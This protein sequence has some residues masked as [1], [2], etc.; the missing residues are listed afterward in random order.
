MRHFRSELMPSRAAWK[1]VQP[2]LDYKEAG[3]RVHEYE[4]GTWG[5]VAAGK[6]IAK[7]VAYGVNQ[8]AK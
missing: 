8:A 1:F 4:A 3:G 7:V 2:I 5:P 6:L